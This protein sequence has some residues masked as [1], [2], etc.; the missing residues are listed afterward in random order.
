MS[1]GEKVLLTFASQ[2]HARQSLAWPAIID[3]V[4]NDNNGTDAL[5]HQSINGGNENDKR[6]S[7][8]RSP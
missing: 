2:K 1:F 4:N 3:F 8:Q 5:F 6:R 7:N